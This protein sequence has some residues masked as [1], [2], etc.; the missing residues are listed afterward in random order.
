M[1][2][3]G[4]MSFELKVICERGKFFIQTGTSNTFLKF[5]NSSVKKFQQDIP[6][7]AL[8]RIIDLIDNDCRDEASI[9]WTRACEIAGARPAHRRRTLLF[10]ISYG[11][12]AGMALYAFL[13]VI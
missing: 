8:Q 2:I 11:I 7:I 1:Y 4:V 10:F 13:R 5:L 6:S 12:V 9:L 3:V